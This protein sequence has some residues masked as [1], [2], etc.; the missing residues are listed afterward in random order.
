MN[1]WLLTWEGTTANVTPENKIAAIVSARRSS[2]FIEDL[3][4]VLYT[5]SVDAAYDAVR[6]L[7]KKGRRQRELRPTFSRGDRLFYGRNPM[8]F[9]RRVKDL[10]VVRDEQRGTE[11]VGWIDPPYLK[12]LAPGEMPVVADPERQCEVVR[13]LE[14]TLSRD[15]NW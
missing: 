2:S 3:M 10:T 11:T 6:M 8:L 15:L 13:K 4:D 7:Y 9:A 14:S 5:R 12:I 1:A